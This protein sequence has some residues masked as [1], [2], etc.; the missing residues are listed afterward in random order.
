MGNSKKPDRDVS[1]LEREIRRERKFTVS[2]A[3][4]RE[5][6]G[7]L[8]GASPVARAEQVLLEISHFLDARLEDPEG[9]L[10]ETV[11]ANLGDDTPL[12]SRHFEVPLAA[13]DA[14]LDRVLNS[15]AALDTL[16]RQTDARWG[17]TYGERPYFHQEGQPPH[18][19]DPYTRE[20]VSLSL[21]RLREQLPD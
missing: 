16:V 7:T 21:T 1:D 15:A 13:L 11:V 14:F 19:D 12:L 2:E 4:G 10:R 5:A 9:S 8:K 20:G 18:P 3:I 17:R 6:A